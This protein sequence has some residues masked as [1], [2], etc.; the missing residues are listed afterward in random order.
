MD[1]SNVVRLGQLTDKGGLVQLVAQHGHVVV[2]NGGKLLLVAH[3]ATTRVHACNVADE[4]FE[5]G[6]SPYPKNPMWN[7]QSLDE[8]CADP[9]AS[10]AA[11]TENPHTLLILTNSHGVPVMVLQSYLP[12][13]GNDVLTKI[14]ELE[15]LLGS[16]GGNAVEALQTE[17][18]RTV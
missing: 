1:S 3:S 18:T 9:A 2:T 12:S 14:H 16:V 11:M 15:Q 10:I 17:L 5:R 7:G 13:V 8:F 6:L 4:W